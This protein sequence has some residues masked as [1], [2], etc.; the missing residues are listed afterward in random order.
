M[1]LRDVHD[2]LQTLPPHVRA[3]DVLGFVRSERES[4]SSIE[5]L[6]GYAV[7]LTR[8][9]RLARGE[10]TRSWPEVE[11]EPRPG[12]LDEMASAETASRVAE[13]HPEDLHPELSQAV[14]ARLHDVLDEILGALR[15]KRRT[16]PFTEKVA[17]IWSR[18]AS[19]LPV[20]AETKLKLDAV[21]QRL[22]RVGSA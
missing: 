3:C 6:A 7:R 8:V 4:P 12:F 2:L 22:E 16:G 11:L 9:L 14:E 13:P 1:S 15:R 19:E 17:E 20:H 5:S 21:G 10:R 18:P